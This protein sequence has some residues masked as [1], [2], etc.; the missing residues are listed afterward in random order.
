MAI[1]SGTFKKIT[2]FAFCMLVLFSAVAIHALA[3]AERGIVIL[4]GTKKT[5]HKVE[6]KV[7]AADTPSVVGSFSLKNLN[8]KD[9]EVL[10]IKIPEEFK[11]QTRFQFTIRYGHK[12][13]ATKTEIHIPKKGKPLTAVAH[14]AGTPSSVSLI[15]GASVDA[16]TVGGLT[17]TAAYYL[18]HWGSGGLLYLLALPG[19]VLYGVVIAAVAPIAIGVLTFSAFELLW[20][21]E[22]ILTPVSTL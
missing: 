6:I 19:T 10:M 17:G 4:N 5:I 13:A 7:L 1:F 12:T 22:L 3:Q 18:A 21:E 9:Q 8:V 15:A 20:T 16:A 14:I 2:A 11:K